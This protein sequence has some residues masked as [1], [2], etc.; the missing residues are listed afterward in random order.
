MVHLNNKW[1]IILKNEFPNTGSN[2]FQR[3]F[4]QWFLPSKN[5]F[6]EIRQVQNFCRRYP[7]FQSIRPILA[8]RRLWLNDGLAVASEYTKPTLPGCRR[9][10]I[11]SHQFTTIVFISK[12]FH[13]MDK[14]AI[15]LTLMTRNGS[16]VFG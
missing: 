2:T 7:R 6:P 13:R 9:S 11:C 5:G 8:M 16:S 3:F 12:S 1:V 15:I 10:I 14:I 4:C